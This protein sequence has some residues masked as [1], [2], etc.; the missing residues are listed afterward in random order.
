MARPVT[1]TFRI[2]DNG[3]VE[4]LKD[5]EGAATKLDTTLDKT[6]K[7]A[8]KFGKVVGVAF[9]AVAAGAVAFRTLSKAV[10]DRGIQQIAE[11]KLAQAL[12]NQGESAEESLPKLKALAAQLQS[13]SNFGDEVQ[14]SAATMLLTF[15][16]VGGSQGVG[17]LLP[18]LLDMAAGL[19]KA[20][21]EGADLNSVAIAIGKSLTDGVSAL[22]RYGIS[23]TDAQE[24]Q[25]KASEGMDR[26][27]LLTEILDANFQGLAE[28]AVDPLVQ[29]QNSAGDLSETLGEG[30]RPVIEEVAT[31]LRLMLD[32][33][34]TASFVRSVGNSVGQAL[35]FLVGLIDD[36]GGFNRS[37]RVGIRQMV[38]GYRNFQKTVVDIQETVQNAILKSREFLG[39]NTEAQEENIRQLQI[40]RLALDAMIQGENQLIEAIRNGDDAL[41]EQA[42]TA[43]TASG[44]LANLLGGSPAGSS[45][46]SGAED[47]KEDDRLKILKDRQDELIKEGQITEEL[48][49]VNREILQIEEERARLKKAGLESEGDGLEALAE[50]ELIV[51]DQRAQLHEMALARARER[52][53]AREK[54]QEAAAALA[55]AQK[56]ALEQQIAN[57]TQ[58]VLLSGNVTET[59]LSQAKQI[60]TAK[61]A[62]T[63]AGA[64]A[65]LGPLAL[66]IGPLVAAGI[67]ALF[68]SVLPGFNEGGIVR[69][70]PGVDQNVIRVSDGEFVMN[71]ESTSRNRP[72]LEAMNRGDRPAIDGR[73]GSQTIRIQLSGQLTG[74]LQKLKADLDNVEVVVDQTR[75]S[76]RTRTT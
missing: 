69:G 70:R 71:R 48:L 1:I 27:N 18:R 53:E 9:A 25:F 58:A 7:G 17:L 45:S 50:Q 35:K 76:I 67:K 47:K 12:T 64:L 74:D 30:L 62:Q 68:S 40:R 54:E 51:E 66:V 46:T 10:K 56:V 52:L 37:V 44:A 21:Q 14:L 42:K 49:A 3:T 16:E 33:K 13:V 60:I 2:D 63:I 57:S 24:E 4:F 34:Q 31:D 19:Q 29:I 43:S 15:K 26:I 11:N 8:S 59:L 20:G 32:D 41:E 61:L 22:K 39:L 75:G 55:E 6:G 36:I 73:S 23:L 72:I 38:I 28:S 65:P 5:S